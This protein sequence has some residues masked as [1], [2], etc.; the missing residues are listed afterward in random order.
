[1][2]IPLVNLIRPRVDA[3]REAGYPGISGTTR[4]LLEHWLDIEQRV[5]HAAAIRLQHDLELA[6]AHR[7]GP[8]AGRHHALRR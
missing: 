3:W 1:M 7:I 6:A 8:W 2:E 5:G 4:T